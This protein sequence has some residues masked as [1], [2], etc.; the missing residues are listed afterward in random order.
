MSWWLNT[1]RSL[2]AL[3]EK[4]DLLLRRMDAQSNREEKVLMTLAELKATVEAERTVI[5]SAIVLL[6]GLA[7]QLK[8]AIANGDPAAIQAIADE[9]DAQSQALAAAVVAN[10]PGA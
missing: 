6:N 7:Q 3:H 1:T 5:D 2:T 10:T 4:I 8:D 9:L